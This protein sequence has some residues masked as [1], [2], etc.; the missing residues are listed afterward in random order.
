M[1]SAIKRRLSGEE[2]TALVERAFQGQ[3]R[4]D[5]Y[6]ELKDGWFNSA[7]ALT[8]DNGMKTV[9]KLAPG[10]EEG[11]LRYERNVMTA[12]VEVLRLLAAAD[13]IPVPGILY[14]ERGVEGSEWFL[15][16]FVPGDPYNKVKEQMGPEERRD[17]EV[18]L[19]RVNRRINEIQGKRFGYYAR[20]DSQGDSWP[21]VFTDMIGGVLADAAD[22]A[23]ALPMDA[24]EVFALL[25]ERQASLAEVTVPRLVHW[26]L[27]DGNVFVKDRRLIAIIDCERAL[28]G[29]PLM[30]YYFRSFVENGAFLD[31]YGKQDFTVAERE[32][33]ALYDLY[34]ALI[35]HIECRFRQYI[36]ANHI[37]WAEEHLAR[38]WSGLNRD[39]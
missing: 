20:E 22:Q 6:E 16:E 30:E 25:R 14:E 32:R 12:E 23:V 9:L 3:R 31:G 28:W 38:T 19:G 1:E 21:A 29:D 7:Y 4:L 13:G 10:S 26:D 35:L 37:R 24:E 15:M 5:G 18:E 36:D 8:L 39:V 27:W 17:I 11:M 33:M 2:L 34:I